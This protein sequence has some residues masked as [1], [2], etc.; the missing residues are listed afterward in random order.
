M[1]SLIG[2]SQCVYL[3]VY[4]SVRA[5][6]ISHAGIPVIYFAILMLAFLMDFGASHLSESI[7]YYGHLRWAFWFLGPPLSVLLI[8]QFSNKAEDLSPRDFLILLVIPI[9]YGLS[10]LATNTYTACENIGNCEEMSAFLNA[11]GL[12]AGAISLLIIFS[13]KNLFTNVRKQRQGKETYW[14]VVSLLIMNV[15]FLSVMLAKLGGVIS[16]EQMIALRTILGLGFVYLVSTSLLRLYPKGSRTRSESSDATLSQEETVL[17]T[18]IENLLS[19]E[20]VYQEPTYSR[21]DLSRECNVS[22]VTISRVIN[23]HFKKSFPQ[24]MNEHR[25]EDAKRLLEQT[26]APVKIIAEDVGFNSLPTFNR[27]FKD[28][29]GDSPSV[30]RKLIKL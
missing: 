24:L 27:V 6:L 22:E 9:C 25:V 2:L 12:M 20:K 4:I 1:L 16:N 26:N 5:G 17:A 28:V 13:K 29:T 30:F 7:S 21:L 11:T 15:C 14:L 23:I 19:Y 3:I 10:Y 18:K 8:V